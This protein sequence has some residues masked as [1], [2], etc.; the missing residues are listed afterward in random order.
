MGSDH[1]KANRQL[2]SIG[3]RISV[4]SRLSAFGELPPIKR[5]IAEGL[6]ALL[7]Q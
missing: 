4:V 5:Q 1:L 6:L 2:T 7:V 3:V